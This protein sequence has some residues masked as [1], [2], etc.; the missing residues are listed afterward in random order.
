MTITWVPVEGKGYWKNG[1]LIGEG[2]E[3]NKLKSIIKSGQFNNS[4]QLHG[5]NCMVINYG[6]ANINIRIGKYVNG[7]EN[8]EIYEYVFVQE[9]WDNFQNDPNGVNSTRYKHTFNNGNWVNTLET[10]QNKKIKGNSSRQGDKF[11]N[12]TSFTV[13]EMP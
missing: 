4:G 8:G 10:L 11:N 6:N 3:V 5:S 12:Y 1:K 9:Q 7:K 13:E 2:M